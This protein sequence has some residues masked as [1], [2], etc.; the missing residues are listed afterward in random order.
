M[1]PIQNKIVALLKDQWSTPLKYR[2]IGRKIGE[3]YPQTVKYHIGA[4][5]ESGLIL[6]HNNFLK[7]NTSNSTEWDFLNLPFFGLAK[8][9]EATV[10]SE[11]LAD[12]YIKISKQVLPIKTIAD[13]FLVR[14][15]GNSMDMARIGPNNKNIEN[16][17][18][19]VV[20]HT[21]WAARDGDYVLSVID[22]CANIKRLKITPWSDQ[23]ALISESSDEY[24]PIIIHESDN[25]FVAGTV[26]DVIKNKVS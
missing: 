3:A 2:E 1:H 11:D 23:I 6:E 14:A 18:F 19:V 22:G 16:G 9:W 12:G 26:V 24:F 13:F 25:Y 4:L 10:F 8:C 17:D 15:T 7:L 5:K 20:D 21:K